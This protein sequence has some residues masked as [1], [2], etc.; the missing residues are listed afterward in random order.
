MRKSKLLSNTL[1]AGALALSTGPAFST[2]TTYTDR[3]SW[4]AAVGSFVTEDFDGLTPGALSTG[5]NNVG[6]ID[7]IISG[8]PGNGALTGTDLD[9]ETDESGLDTGFP[10]FDFLG[11][12]IGFGADWV[13]TA[14]NSILEVTID[15]T[16]ISF[17]NELGG[18]GTGFLGF[19]STN[20][21]SGV[22]FSQ[23]GTANE[24]FSLD[25]LSIAAVPV[26]EPATL[27][28]MGLGLAGIGYRRHRSNKV[29]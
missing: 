1:L 19:V 27:A 4:E 26:P 6:L 5:T 29:A 25:N 24:Q 8:D 22:V 12:I 2:V 18:S 7:V 21:F 28:L 16:L 13:S 20:A 14:T 9:L 15:G 10:A 11:P 17:G 23:T 3:T